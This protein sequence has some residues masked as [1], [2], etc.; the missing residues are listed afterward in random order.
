MLAL[1]LYVGADCICMQALTVYTGADWQLSCQSEGVGRVTTK[2]QCMYITLVD[3]S[4]GA[5]YITLVDISK[6]AVYITLVD[7]SKGAVY[8]TL[9]ILKGVKLQALIQSGI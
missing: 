5:V 6:G 2:Q 3:I 4:E 1:S 8:I 9:D 7:I